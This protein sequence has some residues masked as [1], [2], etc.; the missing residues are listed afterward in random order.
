M[1]AR[2]VIYGLCVAMLLL[3]RSAAAGF[4]CGPNGNPKRQGAIGCDCPP[5][6]QSARD[7]SDWVCVT[8]PPLDAPELRAPPPGAHD[9]DENTKFSVLLPLS[10]DELEV[11][12]CRDRACRD[13]W[14]TDRLAAKT[15]MVTLSWN[16]LPPDQELYWRAR[17]R[18][19]GRRGPFSLARAFTTAARAGATPPPDAQGTPEA[20]STEL[21]KPPSKLAEED[22]PADT[23]DE[24]RRA[25]ET[26]PADEPLKL[27]NT[28]RSGLARPP[29][30]TPPGQPPPSVPATASAERKRASTP[31]AHSPGHVL[32]VASAGAGALGLASLTLGA[33][34]AWHAHTLSAEHS[35]PG[36]TFDPSK[37]DAGRTS[38]QVAIIGFV[39]GSIFVAASATLYWLSTRDRPSVAIALAPMA[40]DHVAVGLIMT[41]VLP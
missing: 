1:R 30:G 35:T 7:G 19:A 22:L 25:D 32:R 13:R 29:D 33:A 14:R 17:G 27:D 41:G 37:D 28:A 15:R 20:P 36:N 16:Q 18:K 26:R 39:S 11:E 5:D 21:A 23:A 24:A 9:V 34:F 2:L 3:V 31:A 12:L 6:K 4:R 38:D 8:I 40:S 10:A